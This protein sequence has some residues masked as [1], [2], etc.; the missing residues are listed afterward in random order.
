MVR[1]CFAPR[2]AWSG[3]HCEFLA[4]RAG[5]PSHAFRNL[6]A[7]YSRRSCRRCSATSSQTCGTN[8]TNIESD[9]S[10]D[11][12]KPGQKLSSTFRALLAWL[13]QARNKAAF[14]ARRRPSLGCVSAFSIWK[15][16]R[17]HADSA[18]KPHAGHQLPKLQPVRR[19]DASAVMLFL[20]RGP[21]REVQPGVPEPTI[22][23][24]PMHAMLQRHSDLKV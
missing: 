24:L 8:L 21:V 19:H 10:G 13:F 20:L 16:P 22:A 2:L 11:T 15:R 6:V 17:E 18:K 4:T 5:S 1:C 14:Q 23:Y 3:L 12:S 7:W 9:S